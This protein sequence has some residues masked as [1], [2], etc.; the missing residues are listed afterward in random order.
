[1]FLN[2][3]NRHLLPVE[4]TCSQG[5]LYISLLKDLREVLY[6][7][8][9]TGGYDRDG[10]IFADVFYKFNIKPAVGTVLINAVQ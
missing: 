2:C 9:T 7:S 10:D 5:S 3:L 8:G 6:L 1:M 4:Y